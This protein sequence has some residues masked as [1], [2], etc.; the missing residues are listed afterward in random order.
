MNRDL[1]VGNKVWIDGYTSI[2]QG[3]S[4]EEVEIEE[5]EYRYDMKTGEKFPVY[6]VSENWFDSRDGSMYNNDNGMYY[7]EELNDLQYP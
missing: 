3:N 7:I 5:I 4:Q 2:A 1:K 6:F